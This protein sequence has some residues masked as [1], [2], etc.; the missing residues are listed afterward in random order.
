MKRTEYIPEYKYSDIPD[1]V[2]LSIMGPIAGETS[3]EIFQRKEKD[4]YTVGRTF[5]M[6]HSRGAPPPIVQRL[7]ST[8]ETAYAILIEPSSPLK[9]NGN[10]C[11][12]VAHSYTPDQKNWFS[13][14]GGLSPVTGKIDKGAY[15]LVFDDIT[16]YEKEA[17]IDLWDYSEFEYSNEPI[18]IMLGYS[19]I[20]AVRKSSENHPLKLKSHLRYANAVARLVAPYCVWL[21]R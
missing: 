5:W 8:Q 6:I 14:P 18:R 10:Q 17:W 9:D 15:A 3:E 11:C 4:I 16:R 21:S 2:I 12:D 13:F 19:T 7:F 20:C 1:H